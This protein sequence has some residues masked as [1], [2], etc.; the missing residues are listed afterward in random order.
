M[1]RIVVSTFL[2]LDGVMEDPG[3]A[4][5]FEHGGWQL[6]FFDEDAGRY[7]SEQLAAADA[8]LLG[9]VTYEGFAAAWPSVTDEEGFANKMN[10][11]PKFVASTTL[12]EAQWNATLIKGDVAEEVAKLKQ[13][14][15]NN[16]LVF[17]RACL[18]IC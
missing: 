8:L 4:E 6:P 13:Q 2:T 17:G 16:M 15:G 10:S 14:P 11:M 1:G 5:G 12:T 3:G 7:M 9:R 18:Y